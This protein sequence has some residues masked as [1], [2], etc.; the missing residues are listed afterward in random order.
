MAKKVY[1]MS[2]IIGEFYKNAIQKIKGNLGFFWAEDSTLNPYPVFF[3]TIAES[4]L[5]KKIQNHLW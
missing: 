3:G 5:W 4:D 2:T 1:P